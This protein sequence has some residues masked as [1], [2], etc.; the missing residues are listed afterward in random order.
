VLLLLAAGLT[1]VRAE[2]SAD[3]A[4]RFIR[5]MTRDAFVALRNPGLSE[6]D[7]RDGFRGL[8]ISHFDIEAASRLAL[9]RYWRVATAE[10]R[11]DYK[12]AFLNLVVVSY[13]KRGRGYANADFEFDDSAVQQEDSFIVRTRLIGVA[14]KKIRIDWRVIEPE[15][16][17]FRIIDVMVEGLSMLQTQRSEFQSILARNNGRLPALTAELRAK[18]QGS[19]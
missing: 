15:A 2:S 18:V 8:L 7:L 1:S 12:E 19:Q 6:A 13:A 10:E 11:A 3:A 9:G 4:N 5:T 14:Q 16:G 17:M